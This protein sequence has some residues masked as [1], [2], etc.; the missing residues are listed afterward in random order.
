MAARPKLTG[1]VQEELDDV[2]EEYELNT[3]DAAIRQVLR[4]AGR[5]V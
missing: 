2:M 5:D 4:E 3:Y 1:I